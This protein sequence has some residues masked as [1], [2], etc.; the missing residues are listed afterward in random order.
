MSVMGFKIKADL[1]DRR[2]TK[3]IPAVD[4]QHVLC[5]GATGS[6][7]TASLILPTLEDRITRGHAIIFFDHK[8]H[9]H[10]K[11]KHLAKN[12][13]R[14]DDVIEI[15]K[16]HASYIN[17]MA[18][19]DTIRLKDLIKDNGM[20]KDPYW[21][22]SA[23]NLLEDIISLLRRLHTIA[24]S[25]Q[26][27]DGFNEKLLETFQKLDEYGI[28]I[29]ENPSFKTFSKIIATPKRLLMFNEIISIL[30]NSL[31]GIIRENNEYTSQEEVARIRLIYAKILTLQKS[32]ETSERFTL[33]QD[34]SDVNSGNN[35]VLQHLDNTIASYAKKDYVNINEYTI[36]ELMQKNAIII[37]DT[38]SFADDIMK[39]FLESILKKAVM[40]LR[41]N[42]TT[43]LSVF[44]D[45][46]NRVLSPSIDLHSDV[47]REAS[48]ELILA[49]QNEEQMINKF[50]KTVWDSVKL[51]IK[52]QFTIDIKHRISYNDSDFMFTEPMH[53]E[54]SELM[55]A[56]HGFYALERNQRN[57]QKH[58]LG[59]S[60]LLPK[61]F[62]V[63]Y[64]LDLFEHESSVY[65]KDRAGT[66]HLY[67][68]HGEEIIKQVRS[69]YPITE[70]AAGFQDDPEDDT[71]IE[72]MERLEKP[73]LFDAE[74]W[75]REW[76]EDD[77]DDM[78]YY[79]DDYDDDAFDF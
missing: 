24:I 59:E 26:K 63:I 27:F 61:E 16:P 41:T 76:E 50:T 25:L 69:L 21:A 43:P 3:I 79:Y 9:E 54:D 38:Q 5:K 23:A 18:E 52:H 75:D 20:N 35:A 53:L 1:A 77:N 13:G 78:Y 44:I 37:V 8:G 6:G 22:N 66:K 4:F 34:K 42:N 58:F 30:P 40:R 31:E 65:L 17:L 36:A 62:T 33:S 7:K 56:E 32:I 55:D 70:K 14:L 67:A 71:D 73:W 2:E 11:V 12:V 29:Y 15:G 74:Y 19:L 28:N 46:A 64:D 68:F 72:E 48:V 45:E 39:I 51:N 10:K 47:L 57:I 60:D 49:I